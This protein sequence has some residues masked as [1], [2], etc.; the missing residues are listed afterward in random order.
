MGPWGAPALWV[1]ERKLRRHRKLRRS[2]KGVGGDQE[3]VC[4]EAKAGDGLSREWVG[5]SVEGC[6]EIE[7]SEWGG[8]IPFMFS[9]VDCCWLCGS[10]F[11]CVMDGK[12]G[13][14]GQGEERCRNA[15]HQMCVT[16]GRLL[17]FL[18]S[19]S[20]FI[21]GGNHSTLLLLTVKWDNINAVPVLAY[22]SVQLV[23]VAFCLSYFL[24]KALF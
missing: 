24:G 6:G 2:S 21:S 17:G 13:W 1:M 18:K 9:F 20:S 7:H 10:H 11:S 8:E 3:S 22:F 12:P 15:V 14:V 23:L 16:L 4:G 19:L 5:S